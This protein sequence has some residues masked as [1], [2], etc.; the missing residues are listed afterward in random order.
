M[1]DKPNILIVEARFYD[2]IADELFEGA[3]AVLDAAGADYERV[4]V[5]G[6]FEIPAAIAMGRKRQTSDEPRFNGFI[7]LGCVIRGETSH[8]DVVAGESGRA[9]MDMAVKER[10]AMGNGILTVDTKAQ[11]DARAGRNQKDK[12]GDAARACL[13]MLDVRRAFNIPDTK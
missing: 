3:K 11:A 10:L 6:V 7:A 2:D 5:P 8:Y 4:Q 12:G 9:L 13:A 1:A